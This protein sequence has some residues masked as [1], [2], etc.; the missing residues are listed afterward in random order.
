MKLS[1]KLKKLEEATGKGRR[2]AWCRL[3]LR[4]TIPPSGIIDDDTP[5][6][7]YVSRSCDHCGTKYAQP[8]CTDDGSMLCKVAVIVQAASEEDF[9]TVA[10]CR[11]AK[12]WITHSLY[13]DTEAV[14]RYY[15]GQ[16]K[17]APDKKRKPTPAQK[18]RAELE[19]EMEADR[20]S[21]ERAM[22]KK[23]GD[24]FPKLDALKKHLSAVLVQ[25]PRVGRTT[26]EEI[27]EGWRA[28]AEL[29]RVMFGEPFADTVAKI[30]KV[31]EAVAL[32]AAL[33]EEA[34][35]KRLEREA[36]F[37]RQREEERRVIDERMGR[38]S[39]GVA[40]PPGLTL[41]PEEELSPAEQVARLATVTTPAAPGRRLEWDE[42][43][44]SRGY[45]NDPPDATRMQGGYSYMEV[46]IAPSA[47][48][49]TQ[50]MRLVDQSD[51]RCRD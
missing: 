35:R 18:L 4:Q 28:W 1:A 32:K 16:R 13:R 8:V 33:K 49:P 22:I 51:S 23:Y 3:N 43:T 29:E 11:A 39:A 12:I 38:R 20:A 34:E 46:D 36:A 7:G 31:A 24:R 26:L 44:K 27:A 50:G 48:D 14:E 10:R 5:P 2:C 42:K 25:E 30:E 19:A 17:A 47:A 9:Y 15:R 37:Q 6:P 41:E 40:A 45:A 21:R